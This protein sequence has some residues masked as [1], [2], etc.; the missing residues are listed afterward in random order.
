VSRD[1]DDVLV[2]GTTRLQPD[3]L[4]KMGP[5]ELPRARPFQAEYLTGFTALRYDV[6]PDDA[7][8][9]AHRRMSQVV[10]DDCRADIGGDEQRVSGMDIAYSRA[11]FKLV[12]L[13]LWI[14]TYLYGG[15]TW[16]V[17]VNANTG[18]VV[19]DRPWSVPKITA[20]V[21][22]ALLVVATVVAAVLAARSG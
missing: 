5:W 6:D 12:L 4:D 9:T 20:A 11:M 22:A 14:A 7:S 1:F 13:P 15:R 17:L 21:L 19:G 8:T 3:L 10:E 16:T 18:E 2:S